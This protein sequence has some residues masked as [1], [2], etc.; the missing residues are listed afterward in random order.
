MVNQ[1]RDRFTI[2]PSL[3]AKMAVIGHAGHSGARRCKK[4][5]G[6]LS[7]TSRLEVGVPNPGPGQVPPPRPK[8]QA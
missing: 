8:G 3:E 5:R 4:D 6:G 2:L 7:G 1:E